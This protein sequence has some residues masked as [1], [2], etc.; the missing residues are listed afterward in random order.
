MFLLYFESIQRGNFTKYLFLGIW[1][2]GNICFYKSL[3]KLS[4]KMWSVLMVFLSPGKSYVFL[5]NFGQD[6]LENLICSNDIF[7]SWKII[8]VLRKLILMCSVHFAS[9]GIFTCVLLPFMENLMCSYKGIMPPPEKFICFLITS[10]PPG[11]FDV[12]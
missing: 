11:K 5:R 3:R 9:P 7:S 6:L 1:S 4:S 10:K 2:P 8:C 12:F